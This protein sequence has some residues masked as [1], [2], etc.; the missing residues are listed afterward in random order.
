VNLGRLAMIGLTSF[1]WKEFL[2][3]DAAI[4]AKIL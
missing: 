3:K 1:L 2:V 4:A